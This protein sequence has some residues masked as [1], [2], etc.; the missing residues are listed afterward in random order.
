MKLKYFFGMLLCLVTVSCFAATPSPVTQLQDV[1]N[2]VLSHLKTNKANI[3]RNPE[4]VYGIIRTYLLPNVDNEMMSRSVL[5]RAAWAKATPAQQQKFVALFST[6]MTY[7]YS[8][9]LAKYDN[10]QIKYYPVHG[11]YEGRTMIS[12]NSQMIQPDGPPMNM[13]YNLILHG[14]KWQVYDISVEGISLLESFREQFANIL[15]NEGMDG[16]LKSVASHN[17][18]IAAKNKEGGNE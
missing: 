1:T 3:K 6:L 4:V 8:S 2:Q 13:T 5:G 14:N 10:Q 18:A 7:T 17:E 12:V 9:A 15:S 11:G 16:L